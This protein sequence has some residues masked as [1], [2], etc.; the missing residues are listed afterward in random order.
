MNYDEHTRNHLLKLID[1][2]YYEVGQAGGDGDA[3]WYSRFYKVENIFPLVQEYNNS[4]KFPWN[5]CILDEDGIN[6]GQGQEGVLI[7]NNE[8][9]Y[10]NAPGWQQILIKY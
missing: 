5:E 1:F 8:E 7:T 4:L 6:W 2:L 9:F 3:L 10:K